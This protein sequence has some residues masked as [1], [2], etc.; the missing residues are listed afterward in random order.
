MRYSYIL[1]AAIVIMIT[2]AFV[3]ATKLVVS[4][5]AFSEGGIIPAKYSCRGAQVSPPLHITHVPSGTQSLALIVHDPDAPMAGGFTHWVMWNIDVKG[6]IPQ[7]F[8]GAEQGLNSAK[9]HGYKGM[10]PP[11]GMHHY[12]FYVYALDSRLNL[13]KNTDKAGLEQ[14][15]QGHIIGQGQLTGLFKK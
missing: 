15:M 14:A 2:T 3:P 7:N 6:N 9:E 13:D 10:C 1:M 4:S 8:T 11:S 5:T 12:I